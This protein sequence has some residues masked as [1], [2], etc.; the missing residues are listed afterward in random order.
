MH[1]N[2]VGRWENGTHAIGLWEFVRYCEG[3]ERRPEDVLFEILAPREL[4][5]VSD[6]M[7][8]DQ[9]RR[10]IFGRIVKEAA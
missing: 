4:A 3:L 10:Q 1:R 5:T 6:A 9:M 2:A 7:T 8:V